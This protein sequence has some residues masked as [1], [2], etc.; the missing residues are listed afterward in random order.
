MPELNRFVV[1]RKIYAHNDFKVA[2]VVLKPDSDSGSTMGKIGFEMD[3]TVFEV[4]DKINQYISESRQEG[5]SNS[6]DKLVGF[7]FGIPGL[8]RTVV[9]VLMWMDKH[10]LLPRSIIDAS[11]FHTSLTVTNL[12]SLRINEI[13]HHIYNFGTT[14]MFIAIGMVK[15]HLE[16]VGGQPT[17]VRYLPLGIVMDERITNG[18]Q[19]AIAVHRMKSYL[20]DPTLLEERNENVKLDSPF[21]KK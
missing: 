2:M 16:L 3:D 14:S 11:P 21:V 4:N 15:K 5:T 19:F 17:E 7:L 6:F 18:S 9:S 20:A 10:G 1:N 8:L 13:Y 12:A